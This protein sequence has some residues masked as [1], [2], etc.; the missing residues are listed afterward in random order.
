MSDVPPAPERRNAGLDGLRAVAVTLVLLFH[1]QLP[2][3]GAGFLGVDVFFVISGF[4]ITTL[5]LAERERSGRISLSAFWARRARRLLPALAIVMLTVAVVTL[6]TATDSQKIALRADL[7]STA[8]YV[9]NWHFIQTSSY[10]ASTG[11]ESPLLHTWSLAIEEQFYLLWPLLVIGATLV[12]ARTRTAVIALS[13]TG[14][15]IGAFLLAALWAPG[16]VDR[17]Y[18]GSDARIF[19]PLIGALGAA[20]LTW[21]AVDRWVRRAGPALAIGGVVGL[22]ACVAWIRPEGALYFQ[23]GAVVACVATLA[24]VIA[25]WHERGGIVGSV[26]SWRPIVAIGVISYGVYLWHWPMALWTGARTPGAS[27]LDLR[28]AAALVLTVVAAAIS[29][30][31][32][33]RPVRER[34]GSKDGGPVA[35]RRRG[36]VTLIAVPFVLLLV[37]GTSIATTRVSRLSERDDVVMLVGDSVP[38]HLVP[39]LESAFAERGWHVVSAAH[40]GCSV[41]GETL[42]VD[43]GGPVEASEI[44]PDEVAT[45]QDV[46]LA[47]AR[48]DIVVWWDR[49]SISGFVTATGEQVVGGSPRF[50]ELRQQ[51]LDRAIQHFRDAGA[52]VVLV[53]TEP[54]GQEVVHA[55]CGGEIR[56]SWLQYQQDRYFDVTQRWNRMLEAAAAPSDDGVTFLDV[57]P[58][59]CRVLEPRCNDTVGGVPARKDGIHYQAAGIPL[60]VGLLEDGIAPVMELR[61]A[62]LAAP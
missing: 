27:N 31:L 6:L 19:E 8:F 39:D 13:V 2:G 5:L 52:D 55:H 37:A 3:S 30:A 25:I 51:S 50:W 40:G 32:I 11:G 17:A 7:L 62:M 57:A 26:L 49:F 61:T 4:L 42:L 43:G 9:G 1:L 44:C 15:V 18:M 60:I 23:G 36:R 46:V 38:L 58:S 14:I 34:L 12:V 53:G 41:T 16:V 33:E 28:R 29:Y 45:S 59:V 10:F 35:V 21:A 22:A 48:P 56:C 20:L 47:D 24:I 54:P